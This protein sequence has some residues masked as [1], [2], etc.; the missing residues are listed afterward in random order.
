MASTGPSRT[1]LKE[2]AIPDLAHRLRGRPGT[3]FSVQR[4]P[5]ATERDG[6]QVKQEMD[7][8]LWGRVQIPVRGKK[9]KPTK[10]GQKTQI[11]EMAE[12]KKVIRLEEGISVSE[13]GQ[14]MG[15]KTT[16][17]IR[18]LMAGGTM[19][20]VPPKR[21]VTPAPATRIST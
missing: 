14:R 13:L 17:I 6:T 7:N 16:D 10:K 9:K 12:E 19:A 18:K 4:L 3:W 15:V 2:I 1:H 21:V 8:L 11:T 20:T 5:R